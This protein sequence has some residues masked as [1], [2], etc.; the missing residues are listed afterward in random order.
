MRKY[1][2]DIMD[3]TVDVAFSNP[4]RLVVYTV[5]PCVEYDIARNILPSILH[6]DIIRISLIIATLKKYC[7]RCLRPQEPS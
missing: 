6:N 4:S 2:Q 1:T 7:V 3:L 5:E